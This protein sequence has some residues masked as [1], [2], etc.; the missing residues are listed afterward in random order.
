MKSLLKICLLGC[1]LAAGFSGFAQGQQYFRQISF[2]NSSLKLQADSIKKEMVSNGFMM[3]KEASIRMESG[4]DMPVIVPLNEGTAYDF[5]FIGDNSSK[6][7]EVR[8]FDNNEKQVAYKKH[9]GEGIESNVINFSYISHATQYHVIKPVQVNKKK[10][11]N[12]AGYIMMFK[13]IK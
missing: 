2:I 1:L 6:L 10:K 8:M 9:D 3:V 7:Y 5:V 11:E 4:Y 12:L 13:K